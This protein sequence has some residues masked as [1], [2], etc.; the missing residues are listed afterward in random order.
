VKCL[1]PIDYEAEGFGEFYDELPLWS[2]PFGLMLLDRVP[3]KPHMTILDVGAG[4]GWLSIEL[5]ERCGSGATI[6][7]V[8]PWKSGLERCRRKV[9]HLGLRNITLLDQDAATLDLPA[10]SVDAI[11]S[12]LGFNN[13]AEPAAVL[14]SCY[15]VARHGATVCLTTN[16]TGHMREFYDVYK[17]TLVELGQKDR[18]DV[19]AAHIEHRGTTE[20]VSRL[21]QEAGFEVVAVVNDTLRMRFADGSSLLNH[22]FIRL[23]FVQGWAAV[24]AGAEVEKTFDTLRRKLDAVANTQGD[25]ALT[26]PMALLE[27]RKPLK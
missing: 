1:E 20:S 11:V 6:I 12:N 2:A 7:A 24:A 23:G 21:L 13:F 19:L 10:E 5:A 8:D 15:R 9:E 22:H 18:L 25:L 17:E 16:L 14:H 3:L 4:T 26:I 27:A